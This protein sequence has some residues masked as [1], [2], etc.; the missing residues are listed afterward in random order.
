MLVFGKFKLGDFQPTS[1]FDRALWLEMI[2]L[3]MDLPFSN[4]ALR[5]NGGVKC[6]SWIVLYPIVPN[7]I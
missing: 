1:K 2:R 3:D 7:F 4:P 6:F 5:Q